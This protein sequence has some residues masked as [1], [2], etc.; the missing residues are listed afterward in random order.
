MPLNKIDSFR[1]VF[2][3]LGYRLACRDTISDYIPFI[4]SQEI[5]LIKNEMAQKNV[6]V[7]FD[8]IMRLGEALAIIVC[9]VDDAKDVG[10]YSHTCTCTCTCTFDHIG[11]HFN[12]PHL[13]E[14]TR[15]WISLY[16]LIDRGHDWSGETKQEKPWLRT[17]KQD[18]GVDGR[19]ITR[20]LCSSV[21]LLHSWRNMMRYTNK[22][23][24][25][26]A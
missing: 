4:R 17:V 16:S 2:E 26:F 9:F 6:A 22:V 12:V 3:E 24:G 19:S 15:L 10:C 18:G 21:T 8:G 14:F 11:E 7:I 23:D 13:K 20:F 25:H 5:S 1:S